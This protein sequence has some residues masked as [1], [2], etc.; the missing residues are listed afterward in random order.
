MAKRAC[1]PLPPDTLTANPRAISGIDY[2]LYQMSRVQVSSARPCAMC[3]SSVGGYVLTAC[4]Y[5]WRSV[6]RCFSLSGQGAAEAAGAVEAVAA[7]SKAKEVLRAPAL[8][9]LRHS[10]TL[11]LLQASGGGFRGCGTSCLQCVIRCACGCRDSGRRFWLVEPQHGD[12]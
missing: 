4:L 10:A 5:A 9:A 1:V 3:H 6:V 8:F 2:V 7:L 11:E 12:A